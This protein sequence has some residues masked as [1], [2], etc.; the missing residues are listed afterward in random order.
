MTWFLLKANFVSKIVVALPSVSQCEWFVID[1]AAVAEQATVFAD[2]TC[3]GVASHRAEER[4]ERVEKGRCCRLN[5][6]VEKVKASVG[7]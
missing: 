5:R 4:R 3:E 1:D 2:K 6:F 7:Q